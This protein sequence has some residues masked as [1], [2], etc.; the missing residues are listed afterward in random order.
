MAAED[1]TENKYSM[2]LIQGEG[3]SG[4]VYLG[5]VKDGEKVV[6]KIRYS[7][8]IL[9]AGNERSKFSNSQVFAWR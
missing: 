5:I 3:G 6:S 7:T 9:R 1:T 8:F 2:D 4:A